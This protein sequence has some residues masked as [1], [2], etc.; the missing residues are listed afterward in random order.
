MQRFA[1][2]VIAVLASAGLWWVGWGLHPVPGVAVLAAL[3]VLLLAP[4]TDACWA[5][6]AAFSALLIGELRW[7]PYFVDTLEQ[8]QAV[9]VLLL[10]GSAAVFGAAVLVGRALLVRGRTGLAAVAV[11]AVWVSFEYLLAMMGPFGAWWSVAYTQ[12]GVLPVVR[13]AALTGVWGI[14]F[15][16]LLGSSV[17]AALAA[18]GVTARTRAAERLCCWCR[19]STSPTT[20]GCTAGWRSCAASN[21]GSRWRERRNSGNWC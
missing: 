16:V 5:F 1:V 11:P 21:P 20:R 17:I 6:V 13:M 7:W 18:P 15:A 14:S 4:R 9:T 2:G 3:P 10:A 8:P 19:H 12:A